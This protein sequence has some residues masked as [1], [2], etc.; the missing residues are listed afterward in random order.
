MFIKEKPAFAGFSLSGVSTL[1]FTS[2]SIPRTVKAISISKSSAVVG[3]Q[4]LQQG[5]YPLAHRKI[6]EEYL[7]ILTHLIKDI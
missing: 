3:M 5:I 2:F 6:S 1:S 4:A 7:L